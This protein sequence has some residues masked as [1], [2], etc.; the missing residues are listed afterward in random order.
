MES[1]LQRPALVGANTT[2]KA[3]T[4]VYW[5][6]TALFCL[7]IG[8]TAYAQPPAAGHTGERLDWGHVQT[9]PQGGG[10]RCHTPSGTSRMTT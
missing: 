8:F 7:Q 9:S 5:V 3:D 4:I 2:P 6:V 1:T 10:T